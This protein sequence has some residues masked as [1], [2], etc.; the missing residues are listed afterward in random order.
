[1][2]TTISTASLS[3]FLFSPSVPAHCP[4]ASKLAQ[5]QNI[6]DVLYRSNINRISDQIF[7]THCQISNLLLDSKGVE[8]CFLLGPHHAGP[9]GLKGWTGLIL[10]PHGPFP[11][12]P[13]QRSLF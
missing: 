6:S 12:P 7:Y 2:Q 9:Y 11:T 1:M 4:Q 5:V 3:L 8:S 13:I 10:G